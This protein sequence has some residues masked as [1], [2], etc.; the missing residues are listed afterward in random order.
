MSYLDE[1]GLARYDG[2]VKNWV[3]FK[4]GTVDGIDPLLNWQR[5]GTAGAVAFSPLPAAPIDPTV[6]FLFTETGPASGTKSPDNPSIIT[7]VSSVNVGRIGKN[8]LLRAV[9]SSVGYTISRNNDGSL[10]ISGSGAAMTAVTDGGASTSGPFS[11]VLLDINKSY[12]L[13]VE[14]VSG[15]VTS[16]AVNIAQSPATQKFVSI[17]ASRKASVTF[18][19][20]AVG[21]VDGRFVCRVLF[22]SDAVATNAVLK[23]Q[24]EEGD[25]ATDFEAPMLPANANHDI[26]LG[27]TY[28]GGSVDLSAGT[29]TVTWVSESVSSFSYVPNILTNTIECN[30]YS[31]NDHRSQASNALLCNRFIAV[32][33]YA[34]EEHCRLAGYAAA[35]ER[36][37][38]FYINKSRLDVSG[39]VNPNAPTNAEWLSA[40]N[41]WLSNN[42]LQVVYELFTPYTV[43]LTPTQIYSLSQLDP[44]TPRINTVYSDQQSVQVGYPKSPLATSAE[45]TNAIV[46]L[47]GNV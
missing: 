23:I 15:S 18:T 3:T 37:I 24:L 27:S 36:N 2:L 7:G 32:T 14:V 28:Y 13:S 22:N 35:G 17:P 6:N 11:S 1:N 40:A 20:S 19:P 45:L 25:T 8:L 30:F 47:G 44:Y 39:A 10:Y 31:A 42:P 5:T 38:R 41:A 21:Y 43:Q 4:S 46:S 26:S 9:G 29:M 16:T 34:D 33:G 12:T